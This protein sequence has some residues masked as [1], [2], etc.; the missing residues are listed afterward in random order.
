MLAAFFGTLDWEVPGLRY[1]EFNMYASLGSCGNSSIW[2]SLLRRN[3]VYPYL[4]LGEST[5]VCTMPVEFSSSQLLA[6]TSAFLVGRPR[7]IHV[8]HGVL[9][10][11]V[12]TTRVAGQIHLCTCCLFGLWIG[13]MSVASVYRGITRGRVHE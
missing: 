12:R 3:L 13:S 9:F 7:I 10:L 1:D 11:S 6:F 4:W 8:L 2:A 5:N